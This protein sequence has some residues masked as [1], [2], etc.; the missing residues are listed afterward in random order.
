MASVAALARR[1]FLRLLRCYAALFLLWRTSRPLWWNFHARDYDH[2]LDREETE[3][4][5]LDLLRPFESEAM[6]MTKP[7]RRLE[8]FGTT[9]RN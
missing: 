9:A 4:L 2:W 7:I 1:I 5:P 3:R 8:T 6:E